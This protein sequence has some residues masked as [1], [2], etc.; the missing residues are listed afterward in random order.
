MSIENV[1]FNSKLFFLHLFVPR[2]LYSIQILIVEMQK[3]SPPPKIW[4]FNMFFGIY[5][6]KDSLNNSPLKTFMFSIFEA[7]CCNLTLPILH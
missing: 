6:L 4:K 2:G 7:A 1:V 5:I 3:T